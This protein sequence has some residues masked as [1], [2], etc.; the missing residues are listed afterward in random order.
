[1]TMTNLITEHSIEYQSEVKQIADGRNAVH[2]RRGKDPSVR[3]GLA[4]VVESEPTSCPPSLVFA[5]PTNATHELCERA[6][7]NRA[8]FWA[9][10]ARELL[11]DNDFSQV[12]NWS[13]APFAKWFVGGT[14]NVA[15]NCVD[16]HVAAGNGDRV[17]IQWVGEI[18]DSRAITY[19][20]LQR[21]VSRAAN[22]LAE[23]GLNAGDRVAIYMPM[24]PEAIAAMLACA[25]LGLIHLTIFAGSSAKSLRSQVD[26]AQAKA[27]ITSDYRYRR[28]APVPMKSVVDEALAADDA[29]CRSVDTVIVVR[30]TGQDPD[31][32][33]VEGR[34]VWWQDTVGV[35]SER[36]EAQSFDAEHPLFLLYTSRTD[37]K[38]HGIV[39][40]SG[41][42]L[43]Q[44]RYTFHY[45]FDH[46]EDLDVYW[47]DA[48]LASIAGHTYQVYG[49]LSDGATSVI[50][51]GGVE[52]PDAHRHF[53]II[54]DYGV[55]T[56]YVA[57]KLIRTFMKRGR[58][59]PGA[60]DLSSLRLLGMVGEPNNQ[61]V[62]QW[63]A[64]VIGS[65]RCQ[66]V[67]TWWQTETGAIMIAPL[68]GVN[69]IRAGSP[70]TS[71]P[72]IS[73]HIVDD[74]TD[75]VALGEQGKLVMDR[76]WPSMARGIWGDEGC[77]VET[78]WRRYVDRCWCFTGVE[79]RYD[80]QEA[81]WIVGGDGEVMNA[82]GLDIP[83][84]QRPADVDRS[85]GIAGA[86]VTG[87]SDERPAE[88]T[89]RIRHLA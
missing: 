58:E 70:V 18:G 86:E 36:H 54:E 57:P 78:Y 25:R 88:E 51:E 80:D 21:E 71:L 33:W 15:V 44:A 45:V 23:V 11:W 84:W 75:L 87:A 16:R 37:G 41:G 66:V 1:M 60:H 76:P 85:R 14:I 10:Q 56:Y 38:P 73:A 35:A 9:E 40:S 39:H 77:F 43:T 67:D 2:T 5:S 22:Y 46:K 69:V 28:G 49:P 61:E 89:A 79:A 72:G 82:S 26:D 52:F 74:N 83:D 30:R 65:D 62:R 50:Y 63:Y 81:I 7:N 53:Q 32:H 47:C 24:I 31:L 59:V 27:V 64:D 13:N 20:Q 8:N 29:R 12:L 68:P 6:T 55:T 4:T 42:Y 3:S 19:N 17:A 34:D 48:D